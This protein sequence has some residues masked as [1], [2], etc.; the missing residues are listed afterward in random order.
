MSDFI[1]IHY[2]SS[3]YPFQYNDSCRF[4]FQLK[5]AFPSRLW[6]QG[7]SGKDDMLKFIS[8]VT[9]YIII[10]EGHL[11][12]DV[13]KNIP[14]IIVHNMCAKILLDDYNNNIL[15]INKKLLDLYINGENGALLYREPS[16]TIF[17]DCC[18][19]INNKINEFYPAYNKYISHILPNTSELLLSFKN[20]FNT[21]P[22][23]IGDW[24]AYDTKI[25][26]K[27]Q[28]LLNDEFVFH[29]ITTEYTTNIYLHNE[30]IS[31]EY[32]KADIFLQLH[33]VNGNPYSTI[34]AFCNDLLICGSNIGYL[35][36]IKN[37]N[38]AIILDNNKLTDVIYIAE[39]LRN[40]WSN[41]SSYMHKSYNWFIENLNQGDWVNKLT[42][43]INNFGL[44]FIKKF[45]P[46]IAP[47][48]KIAPSYIIPKKIESSS[49]IEYP[50]NRI[51]PKDNFVN[52]TK[53]ILNNKSV[54][55]I[56][57]VS[58]MPQKIEIKQSA[59]SSKKSVYV[60]KHH[61]TRRQT[62]KN[63]QPKRKHQPI[64]S[65]STRNKSHRNNK[66][67]TVKLNASKSIN[68]LII[69]QNVSHSIIPFTSMLLSK[70][71]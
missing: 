55:T 18:K 31:R 49:I 71:N 25:I 22:V 6:F 19:F 69:K 60:H 1:I 7:P 70:K 9:N 59:Q 30:F 42:Q 14:C 16:N 43:L 61:T 39:N 46:K 24:N 37:E 3:R 34:D 54:D 21:I 52:N 28:Q 17:M 29:Q 23:V 48:K 65:K 66:S 4:D 56:K 51:Y 40:L 58:F 20:S 33:P 10:T 45:I 36:D 47:F 44:Q 26:N 62:I 15:S 12:F 38:I 2:S 53:L 63:A 68:S 8:K 67:H 35:S 27:L 41:R 5:Q 57:S 32:Q 13:P 64:K 11:G 50:S